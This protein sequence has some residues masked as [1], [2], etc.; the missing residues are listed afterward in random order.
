VMVER[1]KTEALIVELARRLTPVR[2]LPS[3][4]RRFT[5]WLLVSAPLVV[6]AVL[7]MGVRADAADTITRGP[8]LLLLA[9]SVLTAGLAAAS[10][11]HFSVPGT[12]GATA[13]WTPGMALVGW[14]VAAGVLLVNTPPAN[15]DATFPI[16][17]LC[18]L[19][20]VGVA[21]LPGAALVA[22]L[23]RGAPVHPAR[24]GALAALAS[25]ALGAAGTQMIC[26]S[27]DPLHLLAG[28]IAIG[29]A[30]AVIGAVAL[31]PA[32]RPFGG[33]ARL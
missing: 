14:T 33:R 11:L 20:I 4:G 30:A 28:H 29:A 22:M 31:A 6:I 25:A 17:L 24:T 13:R 32:L 18:V 12:D 26:P 10:A 15:R 21:M 19:Q 9:L 8:F 2:R 27:D 1:V 7:A 16:H 5:L 3:V 23:R